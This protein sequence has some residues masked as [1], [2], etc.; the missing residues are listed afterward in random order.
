VNFPTEHPQFITI[1]VFE[2]KHLL[3]PDKYKEL[4]LD[5]LEFLVKEKRVEVY[6]FVIM[7]NHFH[8]IWQI[9]EPHRREAV[10][11]DF[12]KYVAQQIKFDLIDNHPEVLKH[13]QVNKQDRKCQFWKRNALSTDLYSSDVLTQKLDYIH[14]NPVKAGLCQLPEDYYFSSARFYLQNKNEFGFLSHYDGGDE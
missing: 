11:R 6:G 5:S 8:L 2:W 7:S 12:L 3:K 1:T 10:Q 14:D 9:Q 13:F 4:I